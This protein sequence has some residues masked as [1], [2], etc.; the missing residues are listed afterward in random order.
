MILNLQIDITDVRQH[1]CYKDNNCKPEQ[2]FQI[3]L[4]L[5]GR[6]PIADKSSNICSTSRTFMMTS[7]NSDFFD[8]TM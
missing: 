1:G 4:F 5:L 8:H 6:F 3:T 7:P 2:F